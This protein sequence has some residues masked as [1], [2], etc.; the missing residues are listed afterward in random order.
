VQHVPGLQ[1]LRGPIGVNGQ[2]VRL[3]QV[4]EP[5]R[6]GDEDRRC[7]QGKPRGQWVSTDPTG[8]IR[9]ICVPGRQFSL[10]LTTELGVAVA[11]RWWRVKR[12]GWCGGMRAAVGIPLGHMEPSSTARVIQGT[13]SSSI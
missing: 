11:V 2:C 10:L 5:Q 8:G 13:T 6:D 9:G 4:S 3:A 12:P 7:Q 1:R